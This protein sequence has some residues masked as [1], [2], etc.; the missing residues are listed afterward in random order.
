MRPSALPGQ[1][2]APA[3]LSRSRPAHATGRSTRARIALALLLV[4]A[5][6][7]AVSLATHYIAY[8]SQVAAP[9]STQT[10]AW[11]TIM[12]L[13]DVNTE[14]NIPT[15]FSSSVLL[16]SA[17][18]ST[19]IAALA[20]R[21]GRRDGGHWIGLAVVVTLMSLDEAAALHE[22]LEAPTRALLGSGVP[23]VVHFTWVLPAALLVVVVASAFVGF[24]ARLPARI[25]RLVVAAGVTYV[26]GAIGLELVGGVLLETQA[27]RALYLLVAVTEEGLEM[28]ASVL[29]LYAGMCCL[30]L[31]P[32]PDGG[33][34]LTLHESM[35]PHARR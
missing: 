35:Q 14:Q 9:Q 26:T 24:L 13:L 11:T 4:A 31:S 23:G 7:V 22:R 34:R 10:A 30:R 29:L 3:R 8:R 17:L 15:W 1:S 33:Y 12:R 28:T 6:L 32:E 19:T 2:T 27:H 21:S 20:R 16:G 25:R 18:L 5:L